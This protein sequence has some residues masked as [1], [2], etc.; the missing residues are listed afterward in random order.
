MA[1]ENTWGFTLLSYKIFHWTVAEIELHPNP[2]FRP[3]PYCP[4]LPVPSTTPMDPIPGLHI[5]HMR[6]GSVPSC[7]SLLA[8]SI[9]LPLAPRFAQDHNPLFL[10]CLIRL[11]TKPQ[12]LS[13]SLARWCWGWSST[14]LTVPLPSVS[15][16]GSAS[17]GC[18]MQIEDRGWDFFPF[19]CSSCQCY[20]SY[21]S[22]P[23]Q[24]L[25]PVT[26]CSNFQYYFPS[27]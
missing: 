8:V 22:L 11:V 5:F 26:L 23:W 17:N 19:A 27:P 16:F 15:L 12:S 4:W 18:Y 13:S 25:L 10:Y 20:S 14:K 24:E 6:V 2:T 21:A 9:L 3:E 1:Y 7:Y